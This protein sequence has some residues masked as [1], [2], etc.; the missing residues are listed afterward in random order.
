MPSSSLLKTITDVWHAEDVHLLHSFKQIIN[1]FISFTAG[2]LQALHT[3]DHSRLPA[4]G[5]HLPEGQALLLQLLTSGSST[6][7]LLSVAP[8]EVCLSPGEGSE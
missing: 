8:L 4:W 2:D 6:S 7:Q 1:E 3:Q 5:D